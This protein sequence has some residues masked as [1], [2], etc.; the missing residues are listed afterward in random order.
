LTLGEYALGLLEPAQMREVA[1]HLLD[2]PHCLA[3]SRTFSAFFAQPDEPLAEQGI[4]AGLRRLIARRIE[5]PSP[6]LAGLRGTATDENVTYAVQDSS[7]LIHLTI[8][9][10][11]QGRPDRVITGFVEQRSGDAKSAVAKL[12]HDTQ[13]V[14]TDDVDDL[15]NFFFPRVPQGTHRLELTTEE[16]VI[17]LEGVEVR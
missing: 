3:E 4:V 5:A 8:Q 2:C 10:A 1:E 7:V 14:Q 11:G 6:A 13:V 16:A 17:L 15:G 9:S 12:Y